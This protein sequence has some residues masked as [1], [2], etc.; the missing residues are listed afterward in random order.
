MAHKVIE[1]EAICSHFG[2]RS[3]LARKLEITPQAVH[4]W[5][6]SIPPWAAIEIEKMSGGKF[7]TANMVI[8]TPKKRRTAA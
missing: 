7:R 1:T 5:G 6:D 2:G 4:Q 8:K 3:E